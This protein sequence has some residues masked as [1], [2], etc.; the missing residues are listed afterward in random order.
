M[1]L[2]HLNR[3]AKRVVKAALGVVVLA[4][5]GRHVAQ[6]WGNRQARGGTLRIEPAWVAL[7]GFL[8]LAGLCACGLYFGRVMN[9]SETPVGLATSVRAYFLSH[10][11]KYVPGKAMVVVMRVGLCTPHGARPA[12]AA[13]ATFYETLVMMAAGSL[14][15]A[16][17]FATAPGA[18]QAVPL[19]LSLGLAAAFLVV[20]DPLVFPRLSALIATPFKSVGPEA[21]PRITR[22]LLVEGLLWTSLNWALL[23]LSQVAVIRGV[24][25][26]ELRPGL[27]PLAAAAVALATVAGFAVAVLPGGLG[28]REGVIITTLV[29]AIG[30]DAA[31]VAALALRLTWVASEVAAAAALV[32]FRPTRTA[33][34]PAAAVPAPSP[35][36][37][38]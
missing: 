16:A 11:G 14:V 8:Y 37:A 29:P 7:G 6:T 9:A 23:G 30:D 5:L 36:E 24:C 27:W 17:G 26:E 21:R 10:L 12:T 19:I 31:V 3:T 38:S 35:P 33:R 1:A 18:L 28:I 22:L 32:P 13:L 25:G 20:V 2:P 34:G 15:A 4:F